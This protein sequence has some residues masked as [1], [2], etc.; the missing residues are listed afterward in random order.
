MFLF[1]DIDFVP[2]QSGNLSRLWYFLP[3]G[4]L[5]TILIETPILLVGLSPKLSFKQRLA[6]G[7]WLTACTYPIV[8][9]VLPALLLLDGTDRSRIVYLAVAETFAPVA[10]CFLFWL[11]F[12]RKNLLETKDWLRS[13]TAIVAANLASFGIGEILN[14]YSWFG[15][16]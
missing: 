3:V 11:A 16:L 1:D 8:I 14:V 10:E 7:A 9:L 12:R 13:F 5:T 6:C 15:L 2:A 4:Y